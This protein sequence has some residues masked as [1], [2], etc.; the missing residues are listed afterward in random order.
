MSILNLVNWISSVFSKAFR[1]PAA[2]ESR[3]L[4]ALRHHCLQVADSNQIVD[5]R[6]EGEHPADPF[7]DTMPRLAHQTYRLDPAK[8]LFHP[9]P[10]SL[11]NGVAGVPSRA[12][13][14]RTATVLLVLRHM[15]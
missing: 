10:L 1:V 8:D 9:F 5:G 3:L 12:A 4:A 11:A 2:L 7:E 15:R 14:N 13:I 6:R